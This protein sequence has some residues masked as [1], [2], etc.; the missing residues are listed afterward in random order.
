MWILALKQAAPFMPERMKLKTAVPLISPLCN[1][2]AGDDL[3]NII[4]LNVCVHF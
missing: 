4:H 3:F 2:C 1:N